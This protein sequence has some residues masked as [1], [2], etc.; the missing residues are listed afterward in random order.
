MS[1]FGSNHWASNH[2]TS[3]HFLGGGGSGIPV[4][5]DDE[6]L[7]RDFKVTPNPA[8]LAITISWSPPLV[9][10]AVDKIRLVRR[11]LGFPQ[12]PD[13]GIIIHEGPPGATHV[14]DTDVVE[15]EC[16][17]YAMFSLSFT[18]GW[19]V[20]P[21]TQGS[22]IPV[23]NGFFAVK[24]FNLLDEQ[25][26]IADKR[27][28]RGHEDQVTLAPAQDP[29]TGFRYND[30]EDGQTAK[31]PLR[32][33]LKIFGAELD[34]IKGLIDCIPHQRDVDHVCGEL[35]P[36]MAALIGATVDPDQDPLLQREE[37]K[38][39]VAGYKVRGTIKG[40]IAKI[41]AISGLEATIQE[42]WEHIL[43][44]NDPDRTSPD[45]TPIEGAFRGL[46]GELLYY[47]SDDELFS[48]LTFAIFVKLP[49]TAGL[50][51]SV[52]RKLCETV[53]DFTPI[54]RT[55]RIRFLVDV[56]SEELE[57]LGGD[58]LNGGFA[59]GRDELH[60]L[61]DSL[62]EQINVA[63]PAFWLFTNL[64]DAQDL[65]NNPNRFTAVS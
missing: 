19:L 48:W 62:V 8:A 13:D 23:S 1:Y 56:Q 9:P 14:T 3:N 18:K 32:R 4:A 58:S 15:C 24:L 6:M 22:G 41:R 10:A 60:H 63:G 30:D 11:T 45:C 25:Y 51:E 21:S 53:P 42:D 29:D 34:L 33:F 46:P 61:S 26:I 57:N 38:R 27:Q 49:L 54:C 36:A 47:S 64:Q 37:V 40:M 43:C 5:T 50:S 35:L 28:N 20:G 17:S 7:V 12:D 2:W 39:T 65:T 55:G 59:G 16:Y 31:G 44:A 52:I